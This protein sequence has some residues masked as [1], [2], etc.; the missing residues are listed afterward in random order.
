MKPV[1]F[2]TNTRGVSVRLHSWMNWAPLFDSSEKRM[3]LLASTPT[4]KPW[5][6]PQPHTSLSP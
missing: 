3:P 4:G 5:I 2:C 6:E 1:M